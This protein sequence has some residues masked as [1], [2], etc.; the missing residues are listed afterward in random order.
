[1]MIFD[2]LTIDRLKAEIKDLPDDMPLYLDKEEKFKLINSNSSPSRMLMRVPYEG[3]MN[4]LYLSPYQATYLLNQLHE[5]LKNA[6]DAD[7]L[8]VPFPKEDNDND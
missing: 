5:S 2:A 6:T 1:M 4:Y 7:I 3:D 8:V